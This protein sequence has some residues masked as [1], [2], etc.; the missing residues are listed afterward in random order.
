MAAAS[1][2]ISPSTSGQRQFD[3][4][5]KKAIPSKVHMIAGAEDAQQS[6]EAYDAGK[7]QVRAYGRGDSASF[8]G[9]LLE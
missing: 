4:K 7:F 9:T 2:P 5:V 6:Q 8:A 1:A 3:N